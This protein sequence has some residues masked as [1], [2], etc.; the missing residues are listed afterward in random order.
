MH[1]FPLNSLLTGDRSRGSLGSSSTLKKSRMCRQDL[2]TGKGNP[3][4]AVFYIHSMT[5][6]CLLHSALLCTMCQG[7]LHYPAGAASVLLLQDWT[8]NCS[9]SPL[10]ASRDWDPCAS[11]RPAG[12]SSLGIPQC[13][14]CLL[15]NTWIPQVTRGQS[16]ARIIVVLL[17]LCSFR[18]KVGEKIT[19]CC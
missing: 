19:K 14:H 7:S 5:F 2:L 3:P 17:L 18:A 13:F 9:S 10:P 8:A 16:L 12:I 15:Q 6:S 1:C 11:P 4:L